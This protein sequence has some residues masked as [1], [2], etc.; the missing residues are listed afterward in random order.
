MNTGELVDAPLPMTQ[1]IL[2]IM[3]KL[4]AEGSGS[5]DHSGIAKH[6]EELTGLKYSE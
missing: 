3:K 1:E 2:E 4:S 5:C 6:Y